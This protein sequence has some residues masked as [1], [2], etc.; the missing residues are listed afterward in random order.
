MFKVFLEFRNDVPL[1]E[2]HSCLGTLPHCSVQGVLLLGLE[3][4]NS[5]ERPQF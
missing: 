5:T 1:F 4:W 3:G 2:Y